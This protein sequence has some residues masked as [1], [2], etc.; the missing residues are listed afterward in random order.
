LYLSYTTTDYSVQ[1]GDWPS[2]VVTCHTT[3]CPHIVQVYNIWLPF[4]I[5]LNNIHL[6]FLSVPFYTYWFSSQTNQP[7]GNLKSQGSLHFMRKEWTNIFI[8]SRRTKYFDLFL[9]LETVT[10]EGGC[11][12]FCVKNAFVVIK[13]PVSK[14]RHLYHQFWH[15]MAAFL[16][17][18]SCTYTIV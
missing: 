6:F 10:M 12:H 2:I 17:H 4:D 5:I 3:F 15:K 1:G 9:T 13:S 8:S 7:T 16:I 18:Y 11:I 14:F